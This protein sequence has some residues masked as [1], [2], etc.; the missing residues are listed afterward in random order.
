MVGDRIRYFFI[1]YIIY[2]IFPDFSNRFPEKRLKTNDF[3]TP[4]HAAAFNTFHAPN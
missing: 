2:Y 4:T 3:F 1:D